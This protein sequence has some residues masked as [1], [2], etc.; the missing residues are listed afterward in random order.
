MKEQKPTM[1]IR[2]GHLNETPTGLSYR[3]KTVAKPTPQITDNKKIKPIRFKCPLTP[4]K[5]TLELPLK[6][7]RK[8]R[9]KSFN[10]NAGTYS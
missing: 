4:I 3:G 9:R 8:M 7:F 1:N 2:I 6:D 5:S 10:L